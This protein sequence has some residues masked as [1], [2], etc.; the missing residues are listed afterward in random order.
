ML[1]PIYYKMEGNSIEQYLKC[2]QQLSQP[3]L[4]KKA[5]RTLLDIEASLEAWNI[6]C[7]L[8]STTDT[9]LNLHGVQLLSKKLNTPPPKEI[10][11]ETYFQ[12]LAAIEKKASLVWLCLAK[13][14]LHL[15]PETPL[16]PKNLSPNDVLKLCKEIPAA[17]SHVRTQIPTD[18]T[19]LKNGYLN[20]ILP[21]LKS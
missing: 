7:Q 12:F 9:E 6:A 20:L 3:T 16:L 13:T 5:N 8:M 1:C 17:L 18:S 2:Y 21:I 15:S 11:I 4:S 10:N 19:H 14:I